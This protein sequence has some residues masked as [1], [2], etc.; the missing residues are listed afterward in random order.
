VAQEIAVQGGALGDENFIGG[1]DK[2]RYSVNT[3][4]SQGPFQVEAE[5]WFQP[6]SYRW[7]DNLKSY[8]AKEPQR[9]TKYYE[10]MA[11]GSGLMVARATT[12]R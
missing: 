11:P 2:I 3:G 9:F 12:T 10:E 5:L 7:A 8:N 6:I 1:S 4:N